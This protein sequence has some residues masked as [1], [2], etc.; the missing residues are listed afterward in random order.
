M[1]YKCPRCG[2]STIY[3]T[4]I[5][6]HYSRITPCDAKSS[7]T[8]LSD[9]L[10]ELTKSK[11]DFV[12]DYCKR[13]FTTRSGLWRHMVGKHTNEYSVAKK[14]RDELKLRRNE[15]EELTKL[16]HENL[17]LRTLAA[18]NAITHMSDEKHGIS[19]FKNLDILLKTCTNA[20]TEDVY[21]AILE[22][23][24]GGT[25]KILSIGITDITTE[26]FHA[27]LKEWKCWKEAIGQLLA[28]NTVDRKKELR[29][30][31]FGRKPKED[32]VKKYIDVLTTLAI[33]PYYVMY[34]NYKCSIT[35]LAT[36][37][38]ELVDLHN[39]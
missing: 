39:L 6:A 2:Y 4:N 38:E 10:E 32:T 37:T 18:S 11:T 9:L 24:L 28:Y 21:Q 3:K 19:K 30:Y 25:H 36:N 14:N 23:Y 1:H 17:I 27:E 33:T 16:R 34:M 31:L 26:H 12:C 13:G 22:S 20:Q 8:P 5:R 29:M 15:A 7:V 35:N